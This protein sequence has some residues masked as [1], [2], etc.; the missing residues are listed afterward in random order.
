MTLNSRYVVAGC[1]TWNRTVFDEV[2]SNYPGTW[3][4][5]GQ[6]EEMTADATRSFDPRYIFFL[7]WSWRVPPEVTENYECVCF[8]MTDLPYGRGGSPLQ[9]LILEGHR[10]TYLTAFKMVTEMDAGP[11]YLREHFC[12][13]GSAE[14][15]LIRA[16]RLSAQMIE[17]IIRLQPVPQPQVG[18]AE[19]FKR[20]KAHESRI[21]ELP[22]LQRLHDFIRMLDAD[23]YPRAFLEYKGFCYEFSRAQVYDGRSVADVTISREPHPKNR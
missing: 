16:C 21:P 12:L 7:H 4:F 1:K 18:K 8:H 22:S 2:I 5:I 10:H 20:R 11:V 14:E 9:N 19:T 15:I 3:K 23:G 6:S 13:E 17:H